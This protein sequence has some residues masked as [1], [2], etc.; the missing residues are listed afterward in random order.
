MLSFW[1]VADRAITKGPLMKLRDFDFRIF[2]TTSR[3]VKEYGIRYDKEFPIPSDDDLADRVFEGGL[4]LYSEV[5]T[6][7][8]D[9][10]RVIQF[11]EE[12]IRQ[13]LV[14]LSRLPEEIEIGE[15]TEKRRLIRRK[16]GDPRKPT[17]VGGVVESNPIE[18]RDFVQLYKSVA[19]EKIIDGIYYGPPPKS[20]EGKKW[21]LNSPLDCHAAK[22]AVSW[23]REALRS[24]GRPGLHL[25]D[26][27]PST[28]GTISA[29]DPGNGLRK[30]DAISL[31][32]ISELKVDFE[33]L[34]KVA[35]GLHS[36]C[37]EN[38]FWT[39]VVG[40]FAGGPEGC[41]LVNV[42]S[43]LSAVMVYHVGG[44]G[45]VCNAS[46]LQNP[47]IN[48]AR[49]TIWVRN[50]S[51]QALVRNTNLICGGG[52]LTAAGPG[53]EQQLWEIAALGV[54]ISCV[55]GHIFHGC[56][57][58]VLVKPNQGT[59]M[60]PRWE[61]EVARASA[62]LRRDEANEV[63]DFILSKYEENISHE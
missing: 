40:G 11:T 54:H 7:C 62:S 52:G 17:I 10:E 9:T 37:L 53:T 55:G 22:S 51:T 31:P 1:E 38:P 13:A 32:T 58:S 27:C 45:Y 36:G 24:V 25:L 16:I 56:R 48:T 47:P 30:T 59:G 46:L 12:E 49:S 33:V 35:Y 4:R 18:G 14:D 21:L 20:I 44:R 8:M 39:S 42:A 26:A 2:N 19:Q 15:G 6:Y 60:E 23:M 41:A 57:K 5:G 3:L 63:I 61:G 34:N 43:A 50:V 28:L 29:F